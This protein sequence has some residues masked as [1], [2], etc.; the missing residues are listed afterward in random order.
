MHFTILDPNVNLTTN[1]FL[2][3]A[4]IINLVY[5][6]P[7]IVKTYKSKS[8]K[9]FSGWFLSLRVVGNI[10]WVAYAIEVDSLLMLINNVVT[11]ISSMF[12]GYY[13]I[14]EYKTES[15]ETINN[16]NNDSELT[17]VI[18]QKDYIESINS[19]ETTTDDETYEIKLN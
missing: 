15:Y 12:I 4:N 8:T 1:I 6:I 7:Q 14:L 11:V 18:I 2:V 19:I 17:D 9:D 16:L 5:N 10:I 3:I 13:K